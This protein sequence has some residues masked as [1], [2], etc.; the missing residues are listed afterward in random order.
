M[1]LYFLG[2]LDAFPPKF[3]LESHS[4]NISNPTRVIRRKIITKKE[5]RTTPRTRGSTHARRLDGR[6]WGHWTLE[7][8]SVRGGAFCVPA[9]RE[10]AMIQWLNGTELTNIFWFSIHFWK[11]AIRLKRSIP[12]QNQ[13]LRSTVARG[14]LLTSSELTD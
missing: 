10:G 3:H 8:W 6:I 12:R 4:A 1:G 9:K 2:P 5:L 11:G 13:S 14:A 7:V